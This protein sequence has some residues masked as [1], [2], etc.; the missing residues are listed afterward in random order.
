MGFKQPVQ[1]KRNFRASRYPC[2][3]FVETLEWLL[4]QFRSIP[5]V[6]ETLGVD[7]SVVHYIPAVE[8][9][10]SRPTEKNIPP[11]VTCQ[12]EGPYGYGPVRR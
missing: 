9:L 1:N 3:V 8:T 4:A 5:E 11:R 10:P 2:D 7:R 12:P 6:K